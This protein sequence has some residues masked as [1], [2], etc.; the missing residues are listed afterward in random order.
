MPKRGEIWL[1]DLGFAAKNT[2]CS[3]FECAF[4]R[5]GLCFN[6]SP[7]TYNKYKTF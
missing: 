1:A 6:N 7:T 4:F 2:A 5:F 3:G